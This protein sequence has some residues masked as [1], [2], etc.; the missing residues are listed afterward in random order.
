M[1]QVTSRPLLSLSGCSDADA[2][3]AVSC[4]DVTVY[5]DIRRRPLAPRTSR[6]G[7]SPTVRCVL[8]TG[9]LRLGI[10]LLG[11]SRYLPPLSPFHLVVPS[12]LDGNRSPI[13]PLI[14][15]RSW[16]DSWLPSQSACL[17]RA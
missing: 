14:G 15:P 6:Q 4:G 7:V 11:V 2:S 8:K 5:D 16:A 1:G 17:S 13:E 3:E 10:A 9:S 12:S